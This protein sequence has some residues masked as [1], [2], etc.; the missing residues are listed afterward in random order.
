MMNDKSDLMT[1]SGSGD[2]SGGGSGGSGGGNHDASVKKR[3]ARVTVECLD[4]LHDLRAELL[5]R[6]LSSLPVSI[7]QGVN[8]RTPYALQIGE[9]IQIAC[10]CLRRVLDGRCPEIDRDVNQGP[11]LGGEEGGLEP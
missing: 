2:G 10:E 8:I 6:G 11:T 4:E 7:A 3:F 1:V 9:V 5:R